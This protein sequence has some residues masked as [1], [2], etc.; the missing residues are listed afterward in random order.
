[1]STILK[2]PTP[3]AARSTPF[4][5]PAA[6]FA[7]GLVCLVTVALA[8]P[9]VAPDLAAGRFLQP[10]VV[11]LTH[12]LTLGWLTVSIA[13]ALGQLFP[14]VL[15]TPLRSIRLAATS[16]AM[17]VGGLALFVSGLVS[18]HGSIV[19][20]GAT[21][22]AIALLLFAGNAYATLWRSSERDLTWWT[23]AAAF[24]F[25]LATIT[26]GVSLAINLDAGHLAERRLEALA[27][28]V[29]VA[30]GGWVLLVILAVGRRLM[31]MFLLSH[32]TRELPLRVATFTMLAGAG[33]LTLFHRLLTE[34]LFRS[35]VLLMAIAVVA[36]GW[37]IAGYVRTRHRPQLDAGLRLVLAGGA[38]V[39]LGVITGV[40]MLVAGGT[41]N[42]ITAYGIALVGGLTLFVAGHYY[43]ILPF[44]LWNHRFAP[45]VGKRPMPKIADLLNARLAGIAGMCSTLGMYGLPVGVLMRSEALT[46]AAALLVTAGFIIEALQLIHLLRTRPE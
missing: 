29:H 25:L 13:G 37:Q 21:L 46:L 36:L 45:L 4:W 12:L 1:M 18:G 15:G 41:P 30:L 23:L 16:G 2:T 27:V 24:A 9:F 10:E 42:R 43:K 40:V 38:L 35:A 7:A 6:H 8:L 19:I 26:F 14:V 28:H 34:W 33:V 39:V 3:A 11:A 31:P 5:L 32:G 20:T 17:L 22:L 44:L